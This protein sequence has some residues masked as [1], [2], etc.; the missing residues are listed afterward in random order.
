[1]KGVPNYV[2]PHGH[3]RSEYPNTVCDARKKLGVSSRARVLLFF[4]QIRQYKN[5]P[6]LIRAFR[7]IQGDVILCIAGRPSSEYLATEVAREAAGDPRVRLHLH[8]VP[9]ERVQLFFR[10]ADLVVL[11]YRD[12]LNS[13]TALLSLSF[14][15]PVLVP[16]RGSMGELRLSTGP[17]WVRTYTGEIGAATIEEAL[18]WSVNR[19]RPDQLCLDHLEWPELARQTLN[20]YAE[21]KSR[22]MPPAFSC[23]LLSGSLASGSDEGSSSSRLTCSRRKDLRPT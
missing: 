19:P 10:A 23:N 21:I 5:V 11:P 3:Y 7:R 22:E 13:G 12:I 2:I 16:D 17:E 9:K 20:A 8:E 18:R 1:L 4:G 15:R 6:A 14:S